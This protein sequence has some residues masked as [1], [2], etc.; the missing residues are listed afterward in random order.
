MFNCN[1]CGHTVPPGIKPIL[2]VTERRPKTYPFRQGANRVAK[3]KEEK[4]D[5]ADS[6]NDFGGAGW[7]A[8]KELKVCQAC[9]K[10]FSEGDFKQAFVKPKETSSNALNIAS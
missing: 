6:S 4:Q 5:R 9:S 3:W 10:K 2:V 7:E 8:A 1:V